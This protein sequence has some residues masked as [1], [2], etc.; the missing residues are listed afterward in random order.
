MITIALIKGLGVI[1]GL[2]VTYWTAYKELETTS[3]Q[4]QLDRDILRILT[5]AKASQ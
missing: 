4:L 2:C 3:E 5:E 1:L